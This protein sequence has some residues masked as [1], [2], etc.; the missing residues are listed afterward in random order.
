MKNDNKPQKIVRDYFNPSDYLYKEC[1]ISDLI[2]ELEALAKQHNLDKDYDILKNLI[3]SFE[4]D[5]YETD[6][7]YNDRVFK[8]KRKEEEE[9]ATYERLKKKFEGLK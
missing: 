7:E 1:T 9:R 4:F 2:G 6:E 5:R 3:F 8:E